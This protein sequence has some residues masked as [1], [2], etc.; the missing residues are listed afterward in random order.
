MDT[1]ETP[2]S[3]DE[4]DN[5]GDSDKSDPEVEEESILEDE[6]FKGENDKSLDITMDKSTT[7]PP[8]T[9]EEQDKS[10]DDSSLN[11]W[12]NPLLLPPH[13]THP[14]PKASLGLAAPSA[15][16]ANACPPPAPPVTGYASLAVRHLDWGWTRA[17][18]TAVVPCP[19]GTTGL[20]RWACQESGFLWESAGPNL[21][22][23]QSIWLKRLLRKLEEESI[24]HLAKV[25][26]WQNLN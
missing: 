2:V 21:S 6:V 1:S 23:C 17:G 18:M 11:T 25:R 10:R 24:V 20:A 7:V 22:G 14:L 13:P 26:I 8:P 15:L 4:E 5:Q 3:F 19:L 12:V 16:P 9:P